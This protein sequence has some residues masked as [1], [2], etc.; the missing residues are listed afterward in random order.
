MAD[1]RVRWNGKEKAL[2][3]QRANELLANG[4]TSA[5]D[6][7]RKAQ[8]ALPPKRRR[9]LLHIGQA[10]WYKPA[11]ALSIPT[12]GLD[13]ALDPA[14]IAQRASTTE[15]REALVEFFAGVI[16]DAMARTGVATQPAA[17]AEASL[18]KSSAKRARGGPRRTARR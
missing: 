1:N 18:R 2:L 13:A 15:M 7:L 16:R 17:T 12:A 5:L 10:P 3:S 4:A 11:P 9:S 6:A 14:A 8:A